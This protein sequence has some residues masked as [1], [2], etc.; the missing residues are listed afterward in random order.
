M[1]NCIL[2]L[3]SKNNDK[4]N[5]EINYLQFVVQPTSPYICKS[6]LGKLRKRWGLIHNNLRKLEEELFNE[7]SC[8]AFKVGLTVKKKV[9]TLGKDSVETSASPK[10]QIILD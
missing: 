1:C 2:C 6:C 4:V 8:K 3:F 5:E 7:Y 10:K 9:Q